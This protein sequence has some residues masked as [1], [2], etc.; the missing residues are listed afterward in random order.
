MGTDH[1]VEEVL[2]LGRVVLQVLR[3]DELVAR[4]AGLPLLLLEVRQRR[5]CRRREALA[6]LTADPGQVTSTRQ[7]RM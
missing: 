2:G 1:A 5:R 7:T 3:A 6:E 4:L